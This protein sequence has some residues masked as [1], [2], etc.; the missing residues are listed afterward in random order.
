MDITLI[1]TALHIFLATLLVLSEVR[2]YYE[3]K[4]LM[5]QIM[6]KNYQEYSQWEVGQKKVKIP[7]NL[8]REP[9]T[10]RI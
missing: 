1:H 7:S 10:I 3:R 2:A 8:N 9:K 4:R 5:N 6:A